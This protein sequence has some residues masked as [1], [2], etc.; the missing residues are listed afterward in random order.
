MILRI[1]PEKGP[2]LNE[3]GSKIIPEVF[4]GYFT[5]ST[6]DKNQEPSRL[7][8][9]DCGRTTIAQA[10]AILRSTKASAVT[11]RAS[12]IRGIEEEGLGKLDV[13]NDPLPQDDPLSREPGADG[14]CA[15]LGLNQGT[16]TDR[17]RLR[18]ALVDKCSQADPDVCG[19]S[20]Q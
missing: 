6:K 8:V 16:R 19:P 9:F 15:I 5:L 13:V 1:G 18:F 3:L 4:E 11:L 2:Y 20:E 7:S 10:K 14:H 17:R 12:D